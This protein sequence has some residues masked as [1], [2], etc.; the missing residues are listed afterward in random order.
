MVRF[1]GLLLVVIGLV[2][3]VY[4]FARYTTEETVIDVGP[5]KVTAER[6]RQIPIWPLAGGAAIVGGLVLA[7]TAGRNARR[8]PHSR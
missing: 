8:D 2:A 3:L 4:P 1:I 6:E 7:I 5:L